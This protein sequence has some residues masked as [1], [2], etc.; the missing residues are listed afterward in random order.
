L[1]K[2]AVIL[3][4]ALITYSISWAQVVYTTVSKDQG[5]D[6]SMYS[7]IQGS[8]YFYEVWQKAKIIDPKGD[9]YN[10]I[11]LN[12]NGFTKQLELKKDEIIKPLADGTFLKVFVQGEYSNE[13]FLKY[14]HPAFG[15]SIV[16]VSYDGKHIKLIKKFEVNL[17]ESGTHMPGYPSGFNK[18]VR[19]LEYYLMAND[20]VY[21]ISLRKKKVIKVL[22]HDSE[23]EQ[24]LKDQNFT[25]K[26]EDEL[27]QLLKYYEANLFQ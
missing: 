17:Q 25:L 18:F 14:I 7:K 9:T 5:I 15:N 13:S 26:T 12:Y 10:E 21:P 6:H 3:S 24:Y 23:I 19:R 27:I 4:L 2:W 16:C 11:A 22:G 8:P 20:N 1:V